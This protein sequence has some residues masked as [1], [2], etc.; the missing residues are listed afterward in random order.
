MLGKGFSSKV[1]KAVHINNVDERYAIKVINLKKFKASN[2]AMLESEI[3][4][5]RTLTHPNIVQFYDAYKTENYYYIITE[6]CPHGDLMQ[7]LNQKK[8]I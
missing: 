7:L 3:E 2:L 4:V 6:Y 1:Y 8:K 5:H